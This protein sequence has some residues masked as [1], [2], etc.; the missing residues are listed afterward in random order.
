MVVSFTLSRFGDGWRNITHSKDVNLA[1]AHG[2]FFVCSCS[3]P[4]FLPPL[5]WSPSVFTNSI[6]WWVAELE[7]LRVEVECFLRKVPTSVSSS[8][9]KSCPLLSSCIILWSTQSEPNPF[10]LRILLLLSLLTENPAGDD[11]FEKDGYAPCLAQ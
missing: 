2:P 11:L 8:R 7:W 4:L 1:G 5:L 3:P 6:S 10:G 9:N